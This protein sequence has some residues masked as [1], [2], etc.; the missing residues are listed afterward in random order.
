MFMTY[1]RLTSTICLMINS[2][3]QPK[4][5]KLSLLKQWLPNSTHAVLTVNF[6]SPEE[7][8]VWFVYLHEIDFTEVCF[9]LAV[10]HALSETLR[11]WIRICL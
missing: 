1:N 7:E 11:Y 8:S 6:P 10:L 3:P 9:V 5:L 4:P 2:M